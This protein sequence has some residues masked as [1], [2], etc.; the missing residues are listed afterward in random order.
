ML[1]C[2]ARLTVVHVILYHIV[3]YAMSASQWP[4]ENVIQKDA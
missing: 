4:A 2:Y 1:T 3:K